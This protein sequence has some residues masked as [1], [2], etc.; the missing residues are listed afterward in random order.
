MARVPAEIKTYII[1]CFK[2][3]QAPISIAKD[4][5]FSEDTIK[6]IVRIP[7]VTTGVT[8]A[9]ISR[10]KPDKELQVHQHLIEQFRKKHQQNTEEAPKEEPKQIPSKRAYNK[11][12]MY[13]KAARE[14]TKNN[15]AKKGPK[16]KVYKNLGQF[17]KAYEIE[18]DAQELLAI[19]YD[20]E[21]I[22]LNLQMSLGQVDRLL[23]KFKK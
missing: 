10:S 22:K 18:Q 19:K 21:R 11:T 3:G 8:S 17:A 16:P 5:G 23:N 7:P 6:K 14:A 4:T 1:N 9:V 2:S 12:G 20:L 13:S 15:P